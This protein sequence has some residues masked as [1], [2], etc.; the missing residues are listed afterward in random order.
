M[1]FFFF[2]NSSNESVGKYSSDFFKNWSR[3]FFLRIRR[4]LQEFFLRFL[5]K[6][7]HRFHLE[8]SFLFL[9]IDIS[10]KIP[11]P[12]PFGFFPDCSFPQIKISPEIGNFCRFL[13]EFIVTFIWNSLQ[14]VFHGL[15]LEITSPEN[16]ST[17]QFVLPYNISN[18]PSNGYPVSLVIKGYESPIRGRR[19]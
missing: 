14:T 5:L 10:F 9:F 8:F 19:V 15:D 18:T 6:F 1:R 2:E 3:F 13:L 17:I 11:L 16:F 12:N 7:I 4:F